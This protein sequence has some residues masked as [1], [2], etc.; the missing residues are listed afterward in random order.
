MAC[1]GIVL[2]SALL[3]VSLPLV[4]AAAPCPSGLYG[5]VASNL[6]PYKPAQTYCS[7]KYPVP[8]VTST[9]TGPTA[10]KT[11]T[12][13]SVTAVITVATNTIA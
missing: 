5:V 11:T 4:E 12:V 3:S 10:T 9:V 7:S 2:I 13:A 6:A 8:A 1:Y